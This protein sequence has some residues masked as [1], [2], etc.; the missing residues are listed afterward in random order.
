[1][2]PIICHACFFKAYGAPDSN[3]PFFLQL[4]VPAGR[5]YGL[6]DTI[7]FHI[8]IS[9]LSCSLYK[10]FSETYLDATS[11]NSAFKKKSKNQKPFI[12]VNLLRQV[13]VMLA[14]SDSVLGE[15]TIWPIPPDLS[16]CGDTCGS[17]QCPEGNI[18]WDGEVRCRSDVTVGGFSV[19]NVQVKVDFSMT[20][21]RHQLNI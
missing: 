18:D 11:E 9:G 1:M 21:Q 2:G 3:I 12:H 5:V 20:F 6:T 19:A 16:S 17:S 10:L 14:S 8:Q 13:S 4:F 7:N 15:G